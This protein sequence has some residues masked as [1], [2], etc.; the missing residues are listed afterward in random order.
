MA[1]KVIE[2]T[3]KALA[4]AL[5]E[6][7]VEPGDTAGQAVVGEISELVSLAINFCKFIDY[8]RCKDV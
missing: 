2:P 8:K 6:P 4:L 7:A 3:R 5:A 1:T